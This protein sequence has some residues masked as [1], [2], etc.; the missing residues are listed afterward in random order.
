M[1]KVFDN[2]QAYN[3]G[4]IC[5]YCNGKGFINKREGINNPLCRVCYGLGRRNKGFKNQKISDI[6]FESSIF[7]RN[8]FSSS[9]FVKCDFSGCSMREIHVSFCHSNEAFFVDSN[10]T[11]AK[12]YQSKFIEC[13]FVSASFIKTIF[14]NYNL[15]DKTDFWHSTFF[16]SKI[17]HNIFSNS[18]F[19]SATFD[20]SLIQNT[21]F[22]NCFLKNTKFKRNVIEHCIFKNC[23]LDDSF[24]KENTLENVVFKNCTFFQSNI[25]SNGLE[26]DSIRNLIID[27]VGVVNSKKIFSI[28]EKEK[29]DKK[30]TDCINFSFRELGKKV[31]Q[32]Y[33]VSAEKSFSNLWA[34]YGLKG[35]QFNK[36]QKLKVLNYWTKHLYKSKYHLKAMMELVEIV[37]NKSIEEYS[38]ENRIHELKLPDIYDHT[39]ELI[40]NLVGYYD[41]KVIEFE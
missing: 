33:T 32:T 18:A 6:D 31:N 24:F 36:A 22:E 34:E 40:D 5:N 20:N 35:E 29:S 16:K 26:I 12:I 1:G 38:K 28:Q 17:T 21:I 23:S 7:T 13:H 37:R 8:S 25:L 3:K 27:N 19:Q 9:E 30:E 39:A 11:A 41:L 4:N 14:L 2:N 10:F 15:F